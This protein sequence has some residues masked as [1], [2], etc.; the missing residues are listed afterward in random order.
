MRE[1]SS[2]IDM[3]MLI[4]YSNFNLVVVLFTIINAYFNITNLKV[5][6]EPPSINRREEEGRVRQELGIFKFYNL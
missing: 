5:I 4:V 6:K 2:Q 1:R 3:N